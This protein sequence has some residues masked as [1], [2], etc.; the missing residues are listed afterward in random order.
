VH[1]QMLRLAKEVVICYTLLTNQHP[2][3]HVPFLSTTIILSLHDARLQGVRIFQTLL[4]G[5]Y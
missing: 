4:A 1:I 5:P 2:R 3:W